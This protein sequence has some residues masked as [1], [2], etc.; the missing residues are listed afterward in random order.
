[1]KMWETKCSSCGKMTPANECPQVGHQDSDGKWIN[2]LCKSCWNK[3]NNPLQLSW[4]ST[5]LLT[6][7]SLVRVQVEELGT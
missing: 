7:L 4:Q 6:L 5:E 3:K 2:S 1:M